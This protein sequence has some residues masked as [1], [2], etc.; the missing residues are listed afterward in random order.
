MVWAWDE[1]EDEDFFGKNKQQIS[2]YYLW[3]REGNGL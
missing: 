3:R 1:D 2:T